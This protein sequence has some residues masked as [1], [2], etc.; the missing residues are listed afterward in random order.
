M[1]DCT[2]KMLE[3][4]QRLVESGQEEIEIGEHMARLTA[5]IISR[6]EFDSNYEKG[7]QIF[8]LLTDLQN[9]CAQASRHLCFPGSR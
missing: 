3:S 4:L 9:L 1:V 5:E 8:R 6:T 7:K 2:S